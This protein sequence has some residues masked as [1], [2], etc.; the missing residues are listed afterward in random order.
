[1]SWKISRD[2]NFE[3]KVTPFM[4]DEGARERH[5]LTGIGDTASTLSKEVSACERF[6]ISR[7]WLFKAT[8]Y[9]QFTTT[10]GFTFDDPPGSLIA[11]IPTVLTWHRN[12]DDPNDIYFERR[13]VV[14]QSSG[15]GDS[16]PSSSDTTQPQGTLTVTFPS[17]GRYVIEVLENQTDD[18]IGSS[19]SLTVV[20]QV[21]DI[22]S[23]ISMTGVPSFTNRPV[24]ATTTSSLITSALTGPSPQTT[25]S[26]GIISKH[27]AYESITATVNGV[28]Q[29]FSPRYHVTSAPSPT[30][31]SAREQNSS[32][33]DP[34]ISTPS[35]NPAPSTSSPPS[36]SES[37]GSNS[38]RHHQLSIIIGATI[39]SLVFLLLLLGIAI[40]LFMRKRVPHYLQSIVSF[41]PDD[42]GKSQ[43]IS[44]VFPVGTAHSSTKI[45]DPAGKD[46]RRNAFGQVSRPLTVDPQIVGSARKQARP[47]RQGARQS[48]KGKRIKFARVKR[49]NFCTVS[50]PLP[51]DSGSAREHAR[52]DGEERPRAALGD[53][54]TEVLRLKTQVY[55]ILSQREAERVQGGPFDRPPSYAETTF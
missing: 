49:N 2:R 10:Y 34:V 6:G 38:N 9:Y 40:F 52:R 32:V 24:S 19:H 20:S 46:R 43:S 30:A 1:M 23:I 3:F 29:D 16:V 11:G 50:E 31:S 42:E 51:V 53:I 55:Q 14:S 35:A 18:V 17:A 26:S 25:S 13:N 28:I 4:V 37:P 8:I 47:D 39:G 7:S 15:N 5:A 21:Q 22:E 33:Y 48:G 27:S 45:K 44:P 36:R 12:S 54:E 41:S